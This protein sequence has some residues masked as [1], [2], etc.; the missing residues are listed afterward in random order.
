[1]LQRAAQIVIAGDSADKATSALADIAWRAAPP[2]K[3]V[4]LVAP[5]AKLAPSHPA[6]GKGPVGG[7][8]AAYVCVGSTCS[9][10]L[11]A[12]DALDQHLRQ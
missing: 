1:M 3:I 4:Q 8:A 9:L 5:G 7:K 12:P 6:S 11:T 2:N 10:P